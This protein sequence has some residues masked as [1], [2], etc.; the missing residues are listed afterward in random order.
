MSKPTFEDSVR[1]FRGNPD[2][3]EVFIGRFQAM[4]EGTFA[5]MKRLYDTPVPSMETECAKITGRM[6]AFDDIFYEMDI[7]EDKV[8]ESESV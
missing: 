7:V 1:Y 6:T 2:L 3:W 5:D 4:R 8:E